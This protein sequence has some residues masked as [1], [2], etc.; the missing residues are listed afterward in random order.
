MKDVV[1][2]EA[3]NQ[4]VIFEV[5]SEDIVGK[6]DQVRKELELF[7]QEEEQKVNQ[8]AKEKDQRQKIQE[9]KLKL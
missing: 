2:D 4:K 3:I 7:K 1:S 6:F 8:E 9:E 5:V